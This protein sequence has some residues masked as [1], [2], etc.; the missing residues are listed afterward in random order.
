MHRKTRII[1]ALLTLLCSTATFGQSE[2]GHIEVHKPLMTDVWKTF[3]M[4]LYK[5]EKKNGKTIYTPFFPASLKALDGKTVTIPGY[6]VPK[7]SSR[8]HSNFF[9]SVLPIFQCMFCGQNGIPAMVEISMKNGEKLSFS[10]DIISVSGT[11][12]LNPSDVNHAEIQIV[13]AKLK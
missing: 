3:D 4:L 9:F 11:V 1:L 2:K 12:R 8:K 13:E 7:N 6:M 10:E 5:V